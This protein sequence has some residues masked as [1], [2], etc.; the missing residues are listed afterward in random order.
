M[1]SITFTGPVITD[2]SLTG[3]KTITMPDAL[4]IIG[5]MALCDT[6]GYKAVIPNPNFDH[7]QLPD[8][9]TNPENI[10]NPIGPD[11]FAVEQVWNFLS[12]HAVSFTTKLAQDSVKNTITLA[13]EQ[14]LN[15]LSQISVS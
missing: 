13:Q 7:K 3:S 1:A 15:Q 14:V 10:P 6:Y 12:T 9:N 8:P 5:C 11:V 2:P 4:M